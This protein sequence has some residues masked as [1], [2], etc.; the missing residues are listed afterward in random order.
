M[1]KGKRPPSKKVA[2]DICGKMVHERGLKGHL[3][4]QHKLILTQ[5]TTQVVSTT[6]EPIKSELGGSITQV[7]PS[8]NSSNTQVKSSNNSSNNSSNTQVKSSNNSSNVIIKT[9]E[10]IEK[11]TVYQKNIE[12]CDY[13]NKEAQYVMERQ[14]GSCLYY[15]CRKCWSDKEVYK[16]LILKHPPIKEVNSSKYSNYNDDYL[17]KTGIRLV[18][19]YTKDELKKHK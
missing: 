1:K 8:N 10:V 3:R 5:V 18:P 16:E 4:L 19:A 6:K 2:C 17:K 15:L 14:I 11:V 7:N 9:T 12:K 13:C